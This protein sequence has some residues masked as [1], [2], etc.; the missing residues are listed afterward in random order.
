VLDDHERAVGS[1]VIY[2]RPHGSALVADLRARPGGIGTVI[3]HLLEET[4]GI[5]AT[6]VSGRFDT[7]LADDVAARGALILATP[8]GIVAH[9]RDRDLL[10]RVT[11]ESTAISRLDGEWW[12]AF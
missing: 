5:G 1:Y 7:R 6:A 3:D 4:A 8:N 10:A 11:R 9:S 12:M 2:T